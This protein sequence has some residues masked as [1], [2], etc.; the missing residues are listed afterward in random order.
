[1]TVVECARQAAAVLIQAGRDSD[2]ARRDV[3]VLIRHLQ[4]WDTADWLTRQGEVVAT[5]VTARLGELVA[6]RAAGEPVAY[7]LGEREFY[8][9]PFQVTPAVLIP[10]PETELVVERALAFI[11]AA[12]DPTTLR[13]ADVGTGS[14]CIAVT[15]AAERAGLRLLATDLSADALAIA[16][17]NAARHG[18]AARITFEHTSL[19]GAAAG[20]DL[21]VSNPPY[22]PEADRADLMPD[23]RDHEPSLALFGGD[24]GLRVIAQL[25]PA[26]HGAL[27]P[28]GAL[29]IEIGIGQADAVSALAC[30]AGFAPP[31]RHHDLAG[32][33][34]VVEAVRP[35]ESV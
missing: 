17:G 21:I 30:A 10:R 4:G 32:I 5:A 25:L 11:D 19:T 1:M 16:G 28:G 9:R 13:I 22:V 8:G 3:A 7:L 2:D 31:A 20:L 6:R 29:I 24:D 33:I 23:V 34:R 18:V 35:A 12:A 15:L 27:R 14:G 26:A